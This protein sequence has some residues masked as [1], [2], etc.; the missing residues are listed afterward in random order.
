MLPPESAFVVPVI[1]NA[2]LV[3]VSVRVIPTGPLLALTLS[4]VIPQNRPA[5][6]LDRFP[7]GIRV[8]EVGRSSVIRP[9]AMSAT[10]IER[11]RAPSTEDFIRRYLSPGQP[12]VIEGGMETWGCNGTWTLPYLRQKCA[13]HLI[14]VRRFPRGARDSLRFTTE[15]MGLWD[16]LD[17]IEANPEARKTHYI[18]TE[19]VEVVLREL[20]GDIRVPS[21]VPRTRQSASLAH[22][23]MWLGYDNYTQ[24]HYHPGTEVISSQVLGTK[25]FYCTPERVTSSTPTPCGASASTGAGPIH[26]IQRK[27]PP[28]FPA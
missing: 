22:P 14:T 11:I 15:K 8:L 16:Y 1:V 28:A 13:N 17:L 20:A 26:F 27:W 21:Y 10:P 25:V 2:P 4:R 18:A 3:P 6:T 24:L 23:T 5:A 7:C 19:L 9:N 12:V